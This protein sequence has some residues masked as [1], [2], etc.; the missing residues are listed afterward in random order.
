VPHPSGAEPERYLDDQHVLLIATLE[1]TTLLSWFKVRA[2]TVFHGSI[3]PEVHVDFTAL[4][5]IRVLEE[6]Q[7]GPG[8]RLLLLARD[9]EGF[10]PMSSWWMSAPVTYCQKNYADFLPAIPEIVRGET[11]VH[12]D[13]RLALQLRSTRSGNLDVAA[14]AVRGLVMGFNRT[15]VR[16]SAELRTEIEE[17]LRA[18]ITD[19]S[20][21]YGLRFYALTQTSNLRWKATVRLADP[22]LEVALGEPLIAAR[23]ILTLRILVERGASHPDLVPR[24]LELMMREAESSATAEETAKLLA[25]LQPPDRTAILARIT[26]RHPDL[27]R[28][29]SA[30]WS[31]GG[32]RAKQ[33]DH[34]LFRRRSS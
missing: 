31:L 34:R 4:S 27:A 18:L 1:E 9:R 16:E 22:L 20:R 3:P 21:E 14:W 29:I 13:A 6:L 15:A 28:A 8:R 26:P 33:L 25:I 7:I 24:A 19:T 32:R 11:V 5:R 10:A 2:E 12:P 17:A 23:A 30:Q